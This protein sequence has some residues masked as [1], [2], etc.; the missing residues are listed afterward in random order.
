MSEDKPSILKGQKGGIARAQ[1][2][3]PERRLEI[4]HKAS[5]ARKTPGGR[6]PMPPEL[7]LKMLP[8]R[9]PHTAIAQLNEIAEATG[10]GHGSI[11][12]RLIEEEHNRVTKGS[13]KGR[14]M[15]ELREAAIQSWNSY[16]QLGMSAP[17]SPEHEAARLA[18]E[19]AIAEINLPMERRFK[20]K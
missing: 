10:E 9:V 5:A 15:S 4:A 17:G 1:A 3:S 19:A 13:M 7:K 8:S 18:Y 11:V 20:S 2:L 16:Y 6:K 12:T 14:S